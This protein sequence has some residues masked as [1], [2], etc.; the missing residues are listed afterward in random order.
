M[1]QNRPKHLR[2]FTAVAIWRSELWT[3]ALGR[4]VIYPPLSNLLLH[5]G[6]NQEPRGSFRSFLGG[7]LS[8]SLEPRALTWAGRTEWVVDK[9][10]T[11]EAAGWLRRGYN[12][13]LNWRARRGRLSGNIYKRKKRGKIICLADCEIKKQTQIMS[14][15]NYHNTIGRNWAGQPIFDPVLR[16]F[17]SFLPQGEKS[18]AIKAP[19]HCCPLGE[20]TRF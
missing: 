5:H 12:R 20:W 6:H 1:R 16:N 3:L 14:L 15:L 13:G 9:G 10:G 7:L 19:R 8:Q 11:W 4:L 17:D 18:V 2:A